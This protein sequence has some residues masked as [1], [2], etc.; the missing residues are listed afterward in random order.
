MGDLPPYKVLNSFP[1]A[2]S[3]ADFAGPFK[4]RLTK[5]C[6]RGSLKAY[7]ALFGYMATRAAHLE[8][9]EDYSA[10]SFNAEATVGIF[11]VTK[12]LIL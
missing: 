12:A 2:Q 9:V 10:E 11:T 3:G 4:V 8:L 5:P 1:F 6:G 7:V